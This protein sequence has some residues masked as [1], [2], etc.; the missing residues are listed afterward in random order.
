MDIG[1]CQATLTGGA[2]TRATQTE[3]IARCSEWLYE[4]FAGSRGTE[5]K[6]AHED[7]SLLS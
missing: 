3:T 1:R 4:N 2:A 7:N 6:L 5:V